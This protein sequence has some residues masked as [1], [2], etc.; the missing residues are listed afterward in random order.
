MAEKTTADVIIG[1][2]SHCLQGM[3]YYNGKPIIKVGSHFASAQSSL[4][5]EIT[6]IFCE[7]GSEIRE[8]MAN[9]FV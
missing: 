4:S 3:E 6:H 5:Q 1:G 9:A 2:H 8:I 7:K